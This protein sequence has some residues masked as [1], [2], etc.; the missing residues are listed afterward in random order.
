MNLVEDIKREIC[1]NVEAYK[2][3]LKIYLDDGFDTVDTL[4]YPENIRELDTVCFDVPYCY[5]ESNKM[6]ELIKSNSDD[7]T[8]REV[9]ELEQYANVRRRE[10]TEAHSE[11][12]A[13]IKAK[14]K[15]IL[16]AE[17]VSDL[18]DDSANIKMF[19]MFFDYANSHSDGFTEL[20]NEFDEIDAF[21]HEVLKL[22]E[23]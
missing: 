15:E 23:K 2:Q 10:L 19:N 7:L 22:K 21:V 1:V 8:G 3:N 9:K 6:S 11:A 18:K 4:E 13:R 20:A 16:M 5:L 17:M 12:H 14:C